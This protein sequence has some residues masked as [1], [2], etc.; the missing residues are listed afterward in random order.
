M[1]PEAK[2]IMMKGVRMLSYMLIP[3]FGIPIL[4]NYMFD[5][6]ESVWVKIMAAFLVLVVVGFLIKSISLIIKGLFHDEE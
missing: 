3:I 6:S 1:S 2:E 5:Q 4:M